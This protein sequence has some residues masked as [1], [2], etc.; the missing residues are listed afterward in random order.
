[1]NQAEP[2]RYTRDSTP[3][4]VEP[5]S[6]LGPENEWNHARQ[7]LTSGFPVPLPP[8]FFFPLFLNA[9]AHLALM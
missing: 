5:A 9:K 8:P 3:D 1:M 7:L 4:S 2:R 6:K